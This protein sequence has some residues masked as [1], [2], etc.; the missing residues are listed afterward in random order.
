[1]NYD[2]QSFKTYSTELITTLCTLEQ[3]IF[4]HPFPEQKIKHIC[5]T[6]Y[7]LLGLVAFIENKPVAYKVGYEQTA[8][9]YYSWIGGVVPEHRGAGLARQL[10]QKQ[11]S[12][13]NDMGYKAVRTHT[14]NRFREMLLLNIRSGFNV[15]GVINDSSDTEPTIVLD[16]DL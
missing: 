4:S 13:I 3:Q 12:I 15:V 6:R 14:Q 8:R 11:H 1:M 9:L 5:K 2:I 10:M 7:N 16:K